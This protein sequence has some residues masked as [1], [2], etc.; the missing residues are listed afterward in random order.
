MRCYHCG[1]TIIFGHSHTHKRGVAGG[2]WK[3]RAPKTRKIFRPNL[4][5]VEIMEAGKKLRVN[6]C[7]KCIKRVKKDLR[8]GVRPFLQIVKFAQLQ[9]PVPPVEE[10]KSELKLKEEEV[11]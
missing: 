4:Q 7:T 8:D 11:S 5:K 10:A 2:R 1:K 3:K 6:L 9:K